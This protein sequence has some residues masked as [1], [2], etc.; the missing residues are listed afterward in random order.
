MQSCNDPVPNQIVERNPEPEE[1]RSTRTL[2]R[3]KKHQVAWNKQR[4]M[5][6]RPSGAQGTKTSLAF[7]CSLAGD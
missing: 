3:A 2:N 1:S 7:S 4:S 5:R 6:D